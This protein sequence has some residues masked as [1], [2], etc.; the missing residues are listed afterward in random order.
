MSP[1]ARALP[2]E[3]AVREFMRNAQ[4]FQGLDLLGL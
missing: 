4:A 3:G 1:R 2:F